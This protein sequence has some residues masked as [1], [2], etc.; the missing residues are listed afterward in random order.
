MKKIK[1]QK[2]HGNGN[3]F[4]LINDLADELSLN[5]EQIAFLC[6]RRTGIGADGLLLIKPVSLEYDFKMLY[7]NA[8]GGRV[9]FCG[10]GGRCIS[11]AASQILKK[12]ELTFL[13]D[14]GSHSSKT[15]LDNPEVSLVMTPAKTI[16]IPDIS[17]FLHNLEIPFIN[18]QAFN[19]GVP[20]IVIELD[21]KK[22][23]NFSKTDIKKL[24]SKIRYSEYFNKDGINVNF[25][26]PA[27]EPGK[28]YQRTY[29]RGVEDETLSCGTG[30]VAVS[31]FWQTKTQKNNF[32]IHT[33]GGIN[34]VNIESIQKPV[35]TGKV[36]PVFTGEVMIFS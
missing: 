14:D 1:F 16:N 36:T 22:I 19:T 6:N 28:Y 18:Y 25:T 24:G 30:S 10:N 34:K 9:D 11:Y 33:P 12:D 13:A 2:I 21:N 5:K 29:E 15:S 26:I 4:V 20:H 27:D 8:D 23:K 7:F 31:L 32:E 35:L 3:D 17:S